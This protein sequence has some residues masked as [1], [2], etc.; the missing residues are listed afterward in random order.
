MTPDLTGDD[1]ACACGNPRKAL[2][3]A[4]LAES[5]GPLLGA[6]AA[7]GGSDFLALR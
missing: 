2:Q 3:A 1:D 4:K 7:V 6:E 5:A